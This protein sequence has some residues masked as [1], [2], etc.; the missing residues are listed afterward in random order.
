M[1]FKIRLN[2]NIK[3]LKIADIDIKLIQKIKI[4]QSA[5]SSSLYYQIIGPLDNYINLLI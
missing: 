5:M 2:Q 4:I 3:F 1:M